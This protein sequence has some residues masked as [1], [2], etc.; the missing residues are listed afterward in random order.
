MLEGSPYIFLLPIRHLVHYSLHFVFFFYLP[1]V[2]TGSRDSMVLDT[3]QIQRKS[4]PWRTSPRG[5]PRRSLDAMT[6][7]LL[8]RD[9]TRM[10]R[11]AFRRHS[12]GG[13]A[14]DGGRRHHRA[15]ED[16]RWSIGSELV[17]APYV[18]GHLVSQIFF[19]RILLLLI[20]RCSNPLRKSRMHILRMEQNTQL[21]NGI[22]LIY[23]IYTHSKYRSKQ[24][25]P[26]P[27]IILTQTKSFSPWIVSEVFEEIV[28]ANILIILTHPNTAKRSHL[29]MMFTYIRNIWQISL[30]PSPYHITQL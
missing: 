17:D 8:F 9:N 3:K 7:S 13:E 11:T 21:K 14:E 26:S 29:F 2:S 6:N 30:L 28:I 12:S 10:R 15:R 22:F 25:L 18:E 19:L 20:R 4:S 24:L 23:R 5:S 16:R 1:R 27:H